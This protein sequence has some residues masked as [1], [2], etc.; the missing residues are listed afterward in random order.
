M[1]DWLWPHTC[2]ACD[3]I[4]DRCP[5]CGPGSWLL[6]RTRAEGVDRTAAL[7]RFDH[8]LGQALRRSKVEADRARMGRLAR[9]WASRLPPLLGSVRPSAIVPAPSTGASLGSRGFSAASVLARAASRQLRIPTVPALSRSGDVRLAGQGREDRRRLLRGRV[10]A[11]RLLPGTV[12]LVDDVLTTG[13]TAEACASELLGGSTDRIL[14][15]VFAAV[16][17]L[18][19]AWNAEPQPSRTVVSTGSNGLLPSPSRVG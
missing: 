19:P 10:R 11:D 1:F 17:D 3:A 12:L 18:Q 2:E 8:P 13:A 15:V 16:A 14:L 5:A 4:G 7:V 6:P 9:L